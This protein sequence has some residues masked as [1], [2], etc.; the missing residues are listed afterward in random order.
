V[1]LEVALPFGKTG[2]VLALGGMLMAF[3]GAAVETCLAAAYS[4]AQFFGWPWGRYCKPAEAPR[5][6]LLWIAGFLIALAVVLTGVKPLDLV[7]WS[8]VFS[9]VVLPLTYLPLLLIANDRKYMGVHANGRIANVLG[10]GFYVVL[11]VAALGAIPLYL[12]TSGGQK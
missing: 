6:T 7:E 9:I 8:I 5:F 2:L 1:A 11:L 3:A 12:L 10:V 4:I